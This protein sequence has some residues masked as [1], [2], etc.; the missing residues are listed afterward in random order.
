[1]VGCNPVTE[2]VMVTN[3]WTWV[4]AS[5]GVGYRQGGLLCCSPW[6]CKS[7]TQL[8]D[9]T[10]WTLHEMVALSFSR[11]WGWGSSSLRDRTQVSYIAGGFFANWATREGQ[12][13]VRIN[14][15]STFVNLLY[16]SFCYLKSFV[17]MFHRERRKLY[18]IAL[19]MYMF[20]GYIFKLDIHCLK[21]KLVFSEQ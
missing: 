9:W 14:I 16:L 11:G 8:S 5:L 1:M 3:W 10:D 4:W 21:Y 15:F 12:L 7:W 17:I 2:D 13:S 19:F 20:M 18:N 6:S